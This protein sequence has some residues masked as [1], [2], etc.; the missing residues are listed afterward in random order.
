MV[1]VLLKV[2]SKKRKV[3]YWK[4]IVN[5]GEAFYFVDNYLFI[6]DAKVPIVE[7]RPKASYAI[8]R[9]DGVYNP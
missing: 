3:I 1:I 5:R 4:N 2:I 7:G 8:W 9:V 6:G